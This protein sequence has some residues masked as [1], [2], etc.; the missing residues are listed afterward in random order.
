[1]AVRYIFKKNKKK[2]KK[3]I[4]IS[5]KFSRYNY[6]T[7]YLTKIGYFLTGKCSVKRAIPMTIFEKKKKKKK[8]NRRYM[9]KKNNKKRSVLRKFMKYWWFYLKKRR[10]I[11]GRLHSTHF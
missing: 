6:L 1:M 4:D 10:K 5:S 7:H 3:V 11:T 2:F 8:K 9:K